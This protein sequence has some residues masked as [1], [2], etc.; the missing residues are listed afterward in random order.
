ML[1]LVGILLGVGRVGGWLL[2]ATPVDTTTTLA[3]EP[4][5]RTGAARLLLSRDA[6]LL[7]IL[8][9]YVGV[10]VTTVLILRTMSA[11]FRLHGSALEPGGPYSPAELHTVGNGRSADVERADR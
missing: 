6:V 11:R 4:R 7:T 3:E 2:A 9:L 1:L 10:A 5:G 8:V